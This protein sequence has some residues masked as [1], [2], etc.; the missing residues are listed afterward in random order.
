MLAL[1]TYAGEPNFQ[2]KFRV[3]CALGLMFGGIGDFLLSTGDFGFHL[4]S[5]S[6]A[7]GH[8]FYIVSLL[9]YF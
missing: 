3:R 5:I 1:M 2:S 8:I 7:I 4:G 9:S 6:F